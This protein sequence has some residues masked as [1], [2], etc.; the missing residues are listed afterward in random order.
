MNFK[1][2]LQA[3]MWPRQCLAHEC[4]VAKWIHID[5]VETEK[6]RSGR[7]GRGVATTRGEEVMGS[8]Q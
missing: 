3:G 2:L 5:K 7:E 4:L 6:G 1:Y 8:H